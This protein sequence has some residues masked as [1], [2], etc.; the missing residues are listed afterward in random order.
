MHATGEPADAEATF[1]KAGRS[2][3]KD[4]PSPRIYEP[5]FHYLR[6]LYLVK[7]GRAMEAAADLEVAAAGRM[8]T[9][10]VERARALVPP[11]GSQAAEVDPRSSLAPQ[12]IDE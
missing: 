6:G 1:V 5:A 7:T 12:V 8:A 11:P 2:R 4:A 3:P 10:Y 9:I